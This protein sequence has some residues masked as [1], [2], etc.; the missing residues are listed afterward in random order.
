MVRNEAR[1]GSQVIQWVSVPGGASNC[2]EFAATKYGW[3]TYCAFLRTV[4]PQRL[5]STSISRS[6]PVSSHVK[7]ESTAAGSSR[8]TSRTTN[9]YDPYPRLRESFTSAL[10]H[11]S[12][13]LLSPCLEMRRWSNPAWSVHAFEGSK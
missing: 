12:P 2:T 5:I 9:R 8:D 1:P 11:L 7:N 4:S 13:S 10:V 6:G 3:I